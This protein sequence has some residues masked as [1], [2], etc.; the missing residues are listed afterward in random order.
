MP[1]LELLEKPVRSLQRK[2]G[3]LTLRAYLVLAVVLV[4]V[5]LVTVSIG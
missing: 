3:L 2:A 4:I 5:K 1:A